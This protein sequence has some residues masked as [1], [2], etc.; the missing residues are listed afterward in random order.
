MKLGKAVRT[1]PGF[2]QNIRSQPLLFIGSALGLLVVA[3]FKGGL[4]GRR[5]SAS[6]R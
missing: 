4:G 5:G 2:L 3:I 6:G 1:P